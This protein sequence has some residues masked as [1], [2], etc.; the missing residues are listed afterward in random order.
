[1]IEKSAGIASYF[2]VFSRKLSQWLSLKLDRYLGRVP[3]QKLFKVISYDCRK[4]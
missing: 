4:R 1:M 2:N 3:K